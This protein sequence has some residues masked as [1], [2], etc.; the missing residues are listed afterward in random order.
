MERWIDEVF[1]S[2]ARMTVVFAEHGIQL[3][4]DA[5]AVVEQAYLQYR[6]SYNS[7]SDLGL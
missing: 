3:P 5:A 1:T 2:F 6:S 4:E 7:V